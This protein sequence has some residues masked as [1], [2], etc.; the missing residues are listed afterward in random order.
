MK[1]AISK[2]Q[3]QGKI[4]APPSKSYS[5]RALMCAALAPGSSYIRFPLEAD[6][7]RAAIDAVTRIGASVRPVRLGWQVN[8]GTLKA[9]QG[10]IFCRESAATFR[11]MAAICAVLPGT[12]RLVPGPG[13][14]RRPVAPLLAALTELGVDCRQESAAVII[15]GGMLTG[16]EVALEGSI[17]SQFISALMLIAPVMEKGL[18]I[19]ITTPARSHSYIE[20]TAAC[21]K[22]FGIRAK[23]APDL[24]SVS[25]PHQPYQAASY[26]VEGDWSQAAALL[27]L[28]ALAGEVLVTNLNAE[29]LQGDRKMLNLLQKMGARFTMRRSSVLISRSRLHA[30]SAD[31]SDCIDLLPVMAVLAATAEGHS[32]FSGIASARHK[33]SNR[34]S[35]VI[36]ELGKMGIRTI[37]KGDSL[38]IIGG[39][40]AGTLLDSHADH[41]LAMAFGVLGAAVGDTVISGAESVSKTYPGFWRGLR[42]PGGNDENRCPI[43]WEPYS[44]S[45]VS[46]RATGTRWGWWWTAVRPDCR[47]LRLI[48]SRTWTGVARA[49]ARPA[50]RAKEKR[51]RWS[52]SRGSLKALPPVRPF[53]CSSG[54]GM[55]NPPPMKILKTSPGRGTLIIL[56][57]SSTEG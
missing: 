28:G 55:P 52:S 14:A 29:S 26:D 37:E 32:Y 45:P 20:M 43:A 10:E 30:I 33:E 21:L 4:E 24:S 39:Q 3:I 15:T 7:T 38:G 1:I 47:S 54:T 46:V 6:D 25:I 27:A 35:A 17:S 41:R 16:G 19:H 9:P 31:L 11:L 36:M 40:P 23:I 13:L 8:G 51:M 56:L 48:S 49:I 12:T 18:S 44:A 5:I 22:E 34:V 50:R 2:S 53:V 42:E 57:M